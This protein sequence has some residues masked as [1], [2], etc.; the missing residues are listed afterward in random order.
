MYV[1]TW[2]FAG[3]V[4]AEKWPVVVFFHPGNFSVGATALWDFSALAAKQKVMCT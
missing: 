1:F 2:L 3:D 4:Q